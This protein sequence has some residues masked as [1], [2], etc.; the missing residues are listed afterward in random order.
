MRRWT[1]VWPHSP[2]AAV[3]GVVVLAGFA[4]I[5]TATGAPPDE[6]HAQV[7]EAEGQAEAVE[8]VEVHAARF[9]FTPARIR[10]APG[11]RL[12]IV[13]E[14]RDVEHGFEIVGT[15]TEVRIP[16]RGGGSVSVQFD[17]VEPGR[18]A[19]R[20]SHKCGAGH[21]DMRGVI[22]VK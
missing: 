13:L 21:V 20:C 1:A 18:Y 10:V 15:D 19:F 17:A 11:T 9:H 12:E 7:D 8:R 14:S 5:A 3:V 4:A 2:T 16:E 6:T 22:V